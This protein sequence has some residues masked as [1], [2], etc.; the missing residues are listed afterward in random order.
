[1]IHR[2]ARSG[3]EYI[4]PVVQPHETTGPGP[5]AQ[6]I[7]EDEDT[8]MTSRRFALVAIGLLSA[9]GSPGPLE[10]F[11]SPPATLTISVGQELRITMRTIGPGEY[12][13]PPTITDSAIEFLG[14]VPADEI[15]RA[16]V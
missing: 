13:S 3:D 8:D 2:C 16:H 12:V 14:L 11:G 9:C 6:A 5:R 4:A 1:M 15:G 7:T 10:A